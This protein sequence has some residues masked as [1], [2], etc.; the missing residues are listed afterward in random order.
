MYATALSNPIQELADRRTRPSTSDRE[1]INLR[2]VQELQRLA[3]ESTIYRQAPYNRARNRSN[4][5]VSVAGAT[6]GGAFS[7]YTTPA[8]SSYDSMDEDEFDDVTANEHVVSIEGTRL[9]SSHLYDVYRQSPVSRSRQGFHALRRLP[10]TATSPVFGL[11]AIQATPMGV[12]GPGASLPSVS[13]SSSTRPLPLSRAA[14]SSLVSRQHTLRRARPRVSEFSDFSA[15]RRNVQRSSANEDPRTQDPSSAASLGINIL[16]PVRSPLQT[17]PP[18]IPPPPSSSTSSI[19]PASP[20]PPPDVMQ[21]IAHNGTSLGRTPQG[22]SSSAMLD[23]EV[24]PGSNNFYSTALSNS[25]TR[26]NSF[27]DRRLPIPR[28]FHSYVPPSG[29]DMLP[30]R[31]QLRDEPPMLRPMGHASEVEDFTTMFRDDFERDFGSWFSGNADEV[32][33]PP[34]TGPSETSEQATAAGAV[35]EASEP[36]A[37]FP[38]P[39]SISPP[40]NP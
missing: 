9:D 7:W 27:A 8:R 25:L 38:T 39:R 2:T 17:V 6:D 24:A 3:G 14:G 13:S 23:G 10:E 40:E 21:A 36:A 11:P 34:V 18:I 12:A 16:P 22:T 37:N 35:R 5:H 4:F 15:R 33:R 32:V 28:V 26:S 20:H 31:S 1:C 29:P 19:S 30:H